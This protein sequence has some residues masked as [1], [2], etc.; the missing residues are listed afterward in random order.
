MLIACLQGKEEFLGLWFLRG[1]FIRFSLDTED[2]GLWLV[3]M[4]LRVSESCF[5]TLS[6]LLR[7][8]PTHHMALPY[9][10]NL[11][12][13]RTVRLLKYKFAS[14]RILVYGLPLISPCNLV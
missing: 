3:L 2:R 9:V 6:S 8:S 4:D 12:C 10:T 7:S 13:P 11:A 5:I 1:T 14:A